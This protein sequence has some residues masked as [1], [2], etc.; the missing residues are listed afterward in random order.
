MRLT[1]EER[2]AVDEVR[3]LFDEFMTGYVDLATSGEPPTAAATGSLYRLVED[4][5]YNDVSTELAG[6]FVAYRRLEGTLRWH[7]LE[8]VEIDPGADRHLRR[9]MLRYCLDARDWKTVDKATSEPASG[10]EPVFA[11]G[12]SHI[13]TVTAVHADPASVGA[14]W[15]LVELDDEVA[16]PC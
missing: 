3:D 11:Q 15:F 9:V 14:R 2:A 1:A 8:V 12:A 7:L 6:N 5:L 4:V 13:V 10:S 16:I